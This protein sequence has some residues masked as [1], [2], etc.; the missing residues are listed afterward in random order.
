MAILNV[1]QVLMQQFVYITYTMIILWSLARFDETAEKWSQK[2]N[3][4]WIEVH[5]KKKDSNRDGEDCKKNKQHVLHS[6]IHIVIIF[7]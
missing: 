6:A 1:N 5:R 7:T 2:Q 3:M 4:D